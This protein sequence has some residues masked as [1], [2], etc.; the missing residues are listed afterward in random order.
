VSE[1]ET[2]I[3][4]INGLEDV[5]MG[6][7]KLN[8]YTFPKNAWPQFHLLPDAEPM[9]CFSLSFG[10]SAKSEIHLGRWSDVS[11]PDMKAF[12]C[13]IINMGQMALPDIKDY[14]SSEWIAQIKFVGYIMSRVPFLQIFWMMHVGNDNTE[15]SNRTIKRAK[16][17]EGVVEYIE[18]QFQKYCSLYALVTST[19]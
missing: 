16:K 9:D 11:V 6:D 3:V 18:K 12:L 14:W 4:C 15:E 17:V 10:T 19:F 8:E 5:I 2:S 1:S 13:L 7:K